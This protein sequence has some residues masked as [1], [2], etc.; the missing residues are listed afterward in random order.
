ME[1]LDF[2]I[3][4]FDINFGLSEATLSVESRGGEI[5][6]A[7]AMG[8]RLGLSGAVQYADQGDEDDEDCQRH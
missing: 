7:F 3:G 4:Q 6:A 2:S 1:R 5:P 8:R